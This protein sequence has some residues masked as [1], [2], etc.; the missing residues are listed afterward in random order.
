MT[1]E[2]LPLTA[3]ATLEEVGGKA[4]NLMRMARA[5]F[6]V[7]PGFVVPTDAYRAFV[8]QNGLQ[9]VIAKA[10]ADAAPDAPFALEAASAR[11]REA[12]Y[13]GQLPAGLPEALERAWRDLGAPPVAMRSSATA[14]DLPDLSFAGQ[15][16]TYLNV[17]GAEALQQAVLGCW[18]SLWTARAIGYRARNGIPHEEAA[19][20]VVVQQMVPADVSGVL[21]TANPLTGRRTETVIEATLGLGEALVSGRVEPDQYVVVREGG[22]WRIRE[23][24][25]GTKATVIRPAPEGGTWIEEE[26]HADRQA[27]PDPLIL[28]LTEWGARIHDL[29]GSPQ[30]VEWAVLDPEGE[31]RICIVQS[32]PITSLYPLPENL[33]PEPLR[34]L[35]GLHLVQG[36]HDPLTPLGREVLLVVLLGAGRIFGYPVKLREQTFIFEAGER[37]W[38]N[39]ATILRHP[40]GR[41][42]F[43]RFFSAIDP[44]AVRLVRQ[45]L[46]DPRMCPGR[47]LLP[48]RVLVHIASFALRMLAAVLQAWRDPEAARRR[49]EEAVQEALQPLDTAL[50]AAAGGDPWAGLQ[51]VV[52]AVPR[53]DR[54]FPE[55]MLPKGFTMVVAGWLPFFGVLQRQARRAAQA[56]GD[57]TLAHLPLEITR[58]LPHNVT[59]EMDLALWDIARRLQ[60]NPKASAWLRDGSPEALAEAWCRGEVP[61]AVREALAPFLERYGAR[62]VGEIDIGR[63]R[64]G[65]DPQQVLHTLQGYLRI[66]DPEQA[67]D[68]VFA[69]GAQQAQDAL[70]RLDAAVRGLPGGWL[71]ARLV[72]W[73]ADRYRALGGTREAPKF[74]AVRMLDRVRRALLAVARDLHALGELERP[75]D[76]FYLRLD[77]L[78]RCVA[79]R[80]ILPEAREAVQQRRAVAEREAR[81]RRLPRLLLSDGTTFYEA[82]PEAPIEVADDARVLRGDPV[83]PGVVEG[84]V[85]VVF[86]PHEAHLQPGEILV[87]RGTD[88][89][90]TPLFLV[91]GGLVMEVGGVMTHGAV[92]AREYGIPAV[93]GVHRA[94]ERLHTG[95]RV[96]VEGTTGVVVVLE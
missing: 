9:A 29:F 30:D 2:L 68:A 21:F 75:D 72:R 82:P 63:P 15:Q 78:A 95:Q 37:L 48:P 4:L 90:W 69:R 20:A 8:A 39:I 1:V 88:P 52:E 49:F 33:P 31:A 58:G 94:T 77:E 32:R 12:F 11:I 50:G 53:M 91:A 47:L 73:A 84:T 43:Q 19:L 79:A 70:E 59:T 23:K 66:T 64:W 14:E 54:F 36:L 16:E 81:R 85:R 7:P 57:P 17:V 35:V 83:S 62:G 10:L 74:A 24:K 41:E 25:L 86:A 93:V 13:R 61:A 67:P 38:F 34:V 40:I 55:V 76:I 92:V 28:R 65:E 71:R 87:C 3:K 6:P 27:L 60:E 44:P 80:R 18:A 46:D 26:E 5:G 42:V 96:R 51:A 22:G 45:L 56:L 89:A